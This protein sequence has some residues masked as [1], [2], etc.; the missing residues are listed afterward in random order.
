[1]EHANSKSPGAIDISN[2][3]RHSRPGV[4]K[5]GRNLLIANHLNQSLYLTN[6]ALNVRLRND[7]L[8][9]ST[10]WA[11]SLSKYSMIFCQVQHIEQNRW[12]NTRWLFFVKFNISSK[13]VEHICNDFCQVRHI[14]QNRWANTQWFL[15][16]SR[17]WAKLLS[18]S[19]FYWHCLGDIVSRFII[20]V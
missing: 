13:I 2:H 9:S 4:K 7:F 18:E 6:Q 8:S 14:E 10:Y 5:K 15:P 20:E 11:K 17:C 19:Q 3:S 16:S 12:A 1:L